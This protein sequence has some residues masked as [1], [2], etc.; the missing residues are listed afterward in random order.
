MSG[1]A[2]GYIDVAAR[3]AEF[4]DK[5]PDGSL[6]MD[7]PEWVTVDGSTFIQAR[8]YAYRTPDD[9]RPGVGHAWEIVPGKTPYTRG[10]ELMNLETSVWGRCLASLGIA[11][12]QGI[13]TTEEIASAQARQGT[14]VETTARSGPLARQQAASASAPASEKQIG[15]LRKLMSQQGIGEHILSDF[16]KSELGF[17]LPVAGLEQLNKQQASRLIESITVIKDRDAAKT[18]TGAAEHDPWQ[19]P[20]VDPETGET[21]T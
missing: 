6:Q 4:Y 5:Y 1:F 19:T 17:E 15:Y 13:A 7:P 10:S 3:I 14:T 2:E 21:A 12:R 16:A 9:Q 8:G 18:S 11:T 20:L